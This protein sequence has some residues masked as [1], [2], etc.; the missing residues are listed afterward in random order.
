[1]SKSPLLNQGMSFTFL[2]FEDLLPCYLCYFEVIRPTII[3]SLESLLLYEATELR[4]GTSLQ[5]W[6]D[7]HAKS[8]V[9]FKVFDLV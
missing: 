7:H 9:D 4:S 1:M 8:R 5:G 6:N 3:D 2:S